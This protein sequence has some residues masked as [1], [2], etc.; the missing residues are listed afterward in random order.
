MPNKMT[1]ISFKSVLCEFEVYFICSHLADYG[2]LQCRKCSENPGSI[3]H[4]EVFYDI[5]ALTEQ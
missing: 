1:H 2:Y 5:L 4:D 3:L